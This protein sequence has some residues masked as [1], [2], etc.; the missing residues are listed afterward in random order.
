MKEEKKHSNKYFLKILI[1]NI[2]YYNICIL[3][4]ST[5]IGSIILKLSKLY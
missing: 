4:V 5:I 2:I 3:N 1:T